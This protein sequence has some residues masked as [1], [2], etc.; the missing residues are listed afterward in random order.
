MT[1]RATST[2]GREYTVEAPPDTR[3]G[4]VVGS[5]GEYVLERSGSV[6]HTTPGGDDW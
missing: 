6:L 2:T 3:R 1:Y 4:D 5:P